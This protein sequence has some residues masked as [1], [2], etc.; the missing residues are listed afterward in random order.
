MSVDP[1]STR[2]RTDE[3]RAW[4]ILH[5]HQGLVLTSEEARRVRRALEIVGLKIEAVEGKEFSL[6]KERQQIA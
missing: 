3:Q 6:P 4:A 1:R 2:Y 5:A